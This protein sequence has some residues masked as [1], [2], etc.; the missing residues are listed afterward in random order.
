MRTVRISPLNLPRN[1]NHPPSEPFQHTLL[2]SLLL[3]GS[4]IPP[5]NHFSIS[6][7]ASRWQPKSFRFLFSNLQALGP[8][9]EP[10]LLRPKTSRSTPSVVTFAPLLREIPMVTLPYLPAPSWG[11]SGKCTPFH[12]AACARL[13]AQ[14]AARHSLPAPLTLRDSDGVQCGALNNCPTSPNA[15]QILQKSAAFCLPQAPAT[16]RRRD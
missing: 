11:K 4:P 10:P 14:P 6:R 2:L 13:G 12:L 8:R 15:A 3:N 7:A 1:P 9:L 16:K 5:L